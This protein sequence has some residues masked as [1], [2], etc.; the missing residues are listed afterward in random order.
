MIS[1]ENIINDRGVTITM[2]FSSSQ[3]PLRPV[4]LHNLSMTQKMLMITDGTLT[5]L[6]E[7]YWNEKIHIAKL[8]EEVIHDARNIQLLDVKQGE[9]VLERK[10]LL[11][12]T[13]SKRNWLYAESLIMP[14]RL[15]TQFR[16]D[17]IESRI[18]IGK[19]WKKYR[20]ETFKEMI[21]YFREPADCLADY[22][23][24]INAEDTLLCRTYRIFTN[25][26]PV[27]K[28]TEKFP[29]NYYI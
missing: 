24:E 17:L 21:N 29:E 3:G 4:D 5:E 6:L 11:Q 26:K 12:G 16:E 25:G 27:M 19:L 2:G 8:S 10:I 20:T 15:E 13:V 23:A 9:N 14:G 18:P 28:I 7:A 22:F 1:V